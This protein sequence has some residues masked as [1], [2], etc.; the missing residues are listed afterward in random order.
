M[1]V[2]QSFQTFVLM[3]V[4]TVH[5]INADVELSRSSRSSS[6]KWEPLKPS[7][8]GKMYNNP[9]MSDVKFTFGNEKS[10]GNA[11][12]FH[13]HKYVLSISSP[14][15]YKMFY[16]NTDTVTRTIHL[17]DHKRE[18]LTGFFGFIY[19]DI[20]PTDFERDFEVLRLLV[21]Y[22]IAR[23]YTVCWNSLQ[24]NT[25]PEKAYKFLEK[26]LELK[27]E[28]L[29]EM[30][31]R[32]IDVLPNEYFAS[33]FFLNIEK[34]TLS[35]LLNRDTLHYNETDIFK[36]V[37]KW[38]DHQCSNQNLK[39]TRENRRMVLG[40]AIYSI[41]FLLMTQTEF[42]SHV[43]PTDI[44]NN[45][46]TVAIIKAMNGEQVPGLV[47]DSVKLRSKRFRENNRL[48][49][50]SAKNSSFTYCIGFIYNNCFTW[51]YHIFFIIGVACCCIIGYDKW[52]VLRMRRRRNLEH[53]SLSNKRGKYYD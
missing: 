42:T 53:K 36:A 13:A 30:C 31:S 2:V 7:E 49:T 8:V 18:T 34:D 33:N 45:D 47:W 35:I 32:V 44:L 1:I 50:P 43:L 38:V 52:T 17:S 5:L 51:I 3:V 4:A 19:K 48:T 6:T 26:F 28:G 29:V 14:V 23:F 40:N 39:P 16:G 20:C 46:E 37:L 10:S 11:E 15:F 24:S 25:K 22:E 21:K 41:R 12:V 27:S 9:F